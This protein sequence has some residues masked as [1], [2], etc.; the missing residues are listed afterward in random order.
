MPGPSLQP[1][2]KLDTH[3]LSKF[4]L[5]PNPGK[6]CFT[7]TYDAEPPV[8]TGFGSV[9]AGNGR[10]LRV[11][12]SGLNGQFEK[13]L[14]AAGLR[15][16]D[17]QRLHQELM[18]SACAEPG[19]LVEARQCPR[20]IAGA[21][22][23]VLDADGG[24]FVAIDTFR[25]DVRPL[26]PANVAMVY[27]IGPDRRELGSDAELLAAVCSL[28]ESLARACCEYVA[29]AA[30]RE[31]ELPTLRR[32]RVALVSGGKYAGKVP[33]DSVALHLLQGL[34]SAVCDVGSDGPEFELAFADGC[35]QRALEKLSA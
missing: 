31:D 19:K 33:A 35:F 16:G 32:V 4:V 30:E 34:A 14:N 3:V 28:G 12:G 11:G 25:E 17:F 29:R 8:E 18:A 27:C 13:D 10:S 2:P 23:R 1:L 26:N 9:N 20:G 24:G 6:G 5:C 22:A 21:F 15:V 7:S